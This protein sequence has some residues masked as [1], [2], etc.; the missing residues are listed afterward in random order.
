MTENQE[1]VYKREIEVLKN[2]I[3]A[4]LDA[5]YDF[6]KKLMSIHGDL[7]KVRFL[8]PQEKEDKT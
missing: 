1:E 8:V 7:S 6:E 3:Q 2:R 4:L 5:L